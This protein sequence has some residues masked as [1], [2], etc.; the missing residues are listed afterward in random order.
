MEY[1]KEL[2]FTD[3]TKEEAINFFLD[4]IKAKRI[5][6]TSFE[7]NNELWFIDE[8]PFNHSDD[9]IINV[10][11]I[12]KY[13]KFLLIK[14]GSDK[15][16]IPGWTTQEQLLSTPARDIYRNG[17][18]FHIV[19]DLNLKRLDTFQIP[20]EKELMADFIINQQKA[21]NIGYTEM[22]SGIL[23]AVHHFSKMAGL[24]FKD[25]NQKDLALLNDEKIKIFTRDA[26]SDNDMLIPD[27]FYQK[28]KD[29]KKY[30]LIKIKGGEYRLVG[31]IPSEIVEETRVVQMIG[32]DSDKAS[33][34]IRRIFAEQ[35][36]PMSE[37]FKIYVDIEKEEEEIIPQNYVP[38][39]LHTEF[40]IG[41]A[42]GTP[43]YI[44][45]ILRKKGFSGAAIT[46]HGTMAGVFSFQKSLLL[47]NLKPIIGCE[48]YLKYFS[49]KRN[50]ITVLV[51]NE[52]GWKNILRLQKIAV[53]NF[54]KKPL[55]PFDELF[56]HSEGLIVLSGCMNGIFQDLIK[57][58]EEAKKIL[59]KFKNTFKDDFY[60]EF[61]PHNI[62]NQQEKLKAIWE[63][64][65]DLGIK[66]VI[67]L[68]SHYPLAEDKKYQDAIKSIAFKTKFGE[69][70]FSD[71][72]FY[73]MT[74]E[75]LQEKVKKDSS[76]AL[77]FLDDWKRNTFVIRDSINFKITPGQE[78]DTLPKLYGSTEERNKIFK[79]KVVKGLIKNTKYN[80]EQPEIKERINLEINRII[81]KQYTNYFLIV[82]EMINWAK[83]KDIFVGP[84]RGSAGA[85]LAGLS[86]G[87]T[88][89]DPIEHD[90]LFDRFL[91]EIRKDMP[92]VDID[93]QDD[94]RQ[95]IYQ[96]LRDTY[97]EEHCAKVITFSRFHPKG[98]LKDI[99]RIFSIPEKEI[100]QV[101]K[102]VIERSGGDARCV[103][104][105]SIV[106]SENK[107]IKIKD[108]IKYKNKKIIA[109]DFKTKKIKET[110]IL[111][112]FD[113]GEKE[114]YE[115][116]LESGKKIKCT[117][118]H[119]F[120]TK[121]GWKRLKD[122]K[123]KDYI[124]VV[125]I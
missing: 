26:V 48:F 56:E 24:S 121:S 124:G 8:H 5:N 78:K 1:I 49:D 32:S 85:S 120:L 83:G 118:N 22:I 107:K 69:S 25:L 67:T 79:E 80:M 31:W 37:L 35:Y 7:Y 51:K 53:E 33:K 14:I 2:V 108:V 39:H 29:I 74:D 54:Y 44:A 88:D 66:G 52:K 70:S 61:Q 105:D 45:E 19:F 20:I 28:N 111:N 68:D 87:I 82:E 97:G 81:S 47:R 59:L 109:M 63:I 86:L 64:S 50:H 100:L 98:I 89:C 94:R 60:F 84:G 34:D 122:I 65:N 27:S 41:D 76:W 103:S 125:N 12:K 23:G 119:R 16:R 75:E 13:K 42:F 101:S 123:E 77:T 92:D 9:I 6:N 11:D 30:I 38:L 112:Y 15:I 99:A 102:L 95:E 110:E 18:Y 21:D 43:E 114:I 17:K 106:Y 57:D 96:H 73:L 55:L 62:N 91:S 117:E 40:S 90:L 71:D 115:V 36:R 113:N 116:T 93:F 58:K 4:K 10:N 46:D 104:G 3:K 72:C